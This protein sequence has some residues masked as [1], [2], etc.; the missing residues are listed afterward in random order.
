MEH[1][2]RTYVGLALPATHAPFHPQD[3]A[4][5][6][7]SALPFEARALL[8][9]YLGP[10]LLLAA[11]GIPGLLRGLHQCQGLAEA[12]AMVAQF[13]G[14]K[15]GREGLADVLVAGGVVDWAVEVSLDKEAGSGFK[16]KSLGPS[17]LYGS[18]TFMHRTV[19]C[20]TLHKAVRVW[21][22]AFPS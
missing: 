20:V 3:P 10:E 7:F 4:W 22:P 11:P 17:P 2:L 8:E 6:A 13:A 15:D 1:V 9:H 21:T 5:P 16:V 14:R 18:S 12:E 19:G